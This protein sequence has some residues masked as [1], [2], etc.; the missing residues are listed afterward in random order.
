MITGRLVLGDL[1]RKNALTCLS[2]KISLAIV[3]AKK[4]YSGN[5]NLNQSD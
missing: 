2:T 4:H 1:L 5:G 3:T